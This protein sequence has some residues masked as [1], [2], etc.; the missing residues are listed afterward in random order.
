MFIFGPN[1]ALVKNNRLLCIPL[2]FMHIFLMRMC[3]TIE[4]YDGSSYS[5]ESHS[6]SLIGCNTHP[7]TISV[8]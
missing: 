1:L 5:K 8:L 2:L 6:V 3:T 4:T 7:R